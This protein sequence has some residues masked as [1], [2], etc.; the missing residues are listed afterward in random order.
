MLMHGETGV[1][2][3][4]SARALAFDLGCNPDESDW[5]GWFEI[6]SGKQTGQ[7]VE[8]F[9]DKLRYHPP[10][11]KNGWRVLLCNECD[12][13]SEGAEVVWLDRLERIQPKSLIIFT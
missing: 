9:C 13:M 3:S 5:G 10:A 4:A 6:A 7:S 8:E 11:S 12:R 2:K 1:G